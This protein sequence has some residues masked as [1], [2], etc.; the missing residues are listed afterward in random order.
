MERCPYPGQPSHAGGRCTGRAAFPHLLS[1]STPQPTA[2]PRAGRGGAAAGL[3]HSRGTGPD[4]SVCVLGWPGLQ[5]HG[6]APPSKA[7]GS[8]RRAEGGE[9]PDSQPQSLVGLSGQS[10]SPRACGRRP[11]LHPRLLLVTAPGPGQGSRWLWTLPSRQGAGSPTGGH[12]TRLTQLVGPGRAPQRLWPL[13]QVLL[14]EGE[15]R[16]RLRGGV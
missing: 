9:G 10:P 7:P 13:P 2:P 5:P 4:R 8:L 1:S 11:A 12:H 15:R 3:V 16:V 6:S 14:Q